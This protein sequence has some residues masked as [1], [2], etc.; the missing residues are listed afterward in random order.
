MIDAFQ[1]ALTTQPCFSE[2]LER[3]PAHS[4]LVQIHLDKSWSEPTVF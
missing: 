3:M 1:A 4:F 2:S